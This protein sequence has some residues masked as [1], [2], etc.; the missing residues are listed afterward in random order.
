[1]YM[2][3]RG[4]NFAS[5]SAIYSRLFSRGFYFRLFSPSNVNRQNKFR[6][7]FIQNLYYILKLF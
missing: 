7:I 1:M 2:E 4:I 3:V 5:V 6:E